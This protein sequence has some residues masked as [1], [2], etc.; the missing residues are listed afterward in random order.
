MTATPDV[1]NVGATPV[2]PPPECLMNPFT[3]LSAVPSFVAHRVH[4]WSVESQHAAR[5]N[6]M[7]ATTALA[8]RRA[9]RLDVD[10]YVAALRARPSGSRL[11]NASQR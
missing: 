10:A 3:P 7:V 11:P 8:E 5:R 4:S 2:F 1:A 6:A 9:E